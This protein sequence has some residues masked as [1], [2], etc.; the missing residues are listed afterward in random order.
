METMEH[1]E[2]I[3]RSI[4][5]EAAVKRKRDLLEGIAPAIAFLE[6]KLADT[7]EALESLKRV[8]AN[9]LAEITRLESKDE[10]AAFSPALGFKVNY[11]DLEPEQPER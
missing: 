7:S 3:H 6:R 9:A 1:Y 2:R 8:R 4:T 11:N 10:D 5:Q